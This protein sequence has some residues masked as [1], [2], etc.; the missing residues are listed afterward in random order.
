MKKLAFLIKIKIDWEIKSLTFSIY[1][2]RVYG[3]F[4]NSKNFQKP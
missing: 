1:T 2:N 4:E 3:N